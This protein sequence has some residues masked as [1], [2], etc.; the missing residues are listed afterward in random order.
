M[1]CS[2]DLGK[3]GL[4]LSA[5]S[6]SCFCLLSISHSKFRPVSFHL[7]WR[8][9][10]FH[11]LVL[12]FQPLKDHLSFYFHWFLLHFFITCN[13]F[14]FS[15]MLLRANLVFNTYATVSFGKEIRDVIWL[16]LL[17]TILGVYLWEI[18]RER[19]CH[20]QIW[21]CPRITVWIHDKFLG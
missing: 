9:L 8:W 20:K 7:K 4:N 19:A 14:W 17:N 18:Y 15:I 6:F 12:I 21:P 10:P 5:L 1:L 3:K 16:V 2:T 13:F 11:V